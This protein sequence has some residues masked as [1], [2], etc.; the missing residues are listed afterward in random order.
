[1]NFAKEL[2]HPEYGQLIVMLDENDESGCPVVS[3]FCKP[4]GLGVCKGSLV[5]ND[6]DAGA[7]QAQKVI[8]EM[9]LETAASLVKTAFDMSD[10]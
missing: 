2:T 1:M 9:T 6:S 5:F 10:E 8:E 4:E 7:E 3:V